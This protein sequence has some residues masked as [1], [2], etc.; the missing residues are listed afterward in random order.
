MNNL[1]KALKQVAKLPKGVRVYRA[2][3][4][5][6]TREKYGF[7]LVFPVDTSK[8]ACE[9]YSDGI[10]VGDVFEMLPESGYN[11]KKLIAVG[12]GL[13]KHPKMLF[14]KEGDDGIIYFEEEV[15][16]VL[17]KMKKIGHIDL[18]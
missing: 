8:T 11:S 7:A 18:P 4:W 14:Y 1:L 10:K 9:Y 17:K 15:S 13:V 2:K 5:K 12:I 3:N 6:Q 16:Q